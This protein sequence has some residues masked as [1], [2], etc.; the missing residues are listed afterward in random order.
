MS[1]MMKIGLFCV[2]MSLGG[3]V[4][5]GAASKAQ[6]IKTTRLQAIEAQVGL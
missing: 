4:L 1:T 5:N 2:V 6:E 3:I